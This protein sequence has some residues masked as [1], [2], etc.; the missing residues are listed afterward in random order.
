MSRSF[1]R[2]Y[3]PDRAAVGKRCRY[4][5]DNPWLTI[6]GVVG[7]VRQA[8]L[9]TTPPMQIYRPLWQSGANSVSVVAR[10]RLTPDRLASDMRAMVRNLDPAVAVAD[11][12]TMSQLV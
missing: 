9:E 4:G 5:P 8:G 12:R 2:R 11:V 1:A 6:V 7:D 10:T 3:F